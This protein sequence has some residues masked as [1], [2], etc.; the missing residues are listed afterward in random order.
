[1][2]LSELN[3]LKKLAAQAVE[4][5]ERIKGLRYGIQDVVISKRLAKPPDMGVEVW[6]TIAG[7]S[8]PAAFVDEKTAIERLIGV[9]GSRS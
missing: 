1:M 3:E 4:H 6:A 8:G 2:I 5:A 9:L 7:I